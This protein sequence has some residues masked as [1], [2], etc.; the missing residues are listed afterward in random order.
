MEIPDAM[1]EYQTRQMLDEFAQQ[2]AELRVSA[3]DQ[4]FQFTGLTE[5]KYMEA[6]E[7]ESTSE[8][9][10]PSGTG[11]SSCRLRSLSC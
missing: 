1:V 3:L 2:N 7:T 5:E 8:H 6:D 4:Y 11:S 10:E 9:P